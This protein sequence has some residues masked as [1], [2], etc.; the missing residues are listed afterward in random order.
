MLLK[1]LFIF[2]WLFAKDY[3]KNF[4]NICKTKQVVHVWSKILNK[5]KVIHAYLVEIIIGFIPK[6][7][8]HLPYAN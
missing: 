7:P 2:R 8:L 1:I 3:E 5:K 4:Q 6:Q